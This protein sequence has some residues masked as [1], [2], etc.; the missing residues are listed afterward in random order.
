MAYQLQVYDGDTLS[1]LE[2][3]QEEKDAA[4]P[5]RKIKEQPSFRVTM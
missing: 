2:D 3:E 1:D 5:R 4:L